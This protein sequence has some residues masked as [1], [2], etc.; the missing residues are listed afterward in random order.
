[1]KWKNCSMLFLCATL[2]VFS[3]SKNGSNGVDGT[4]GKDG[5]NGTNGA[6][7]KDGANGTN[8]ANG[9][10]GANGKTALTR[11][12]KEPAGANCTYGGTK[13]ET[14][15]DANNN[16]V[17]DDNEVTITQT[18]YVCDG[19]GAIYSS[20]I[21]VNVSDTITRLPEEQNFDFKQL[22]PATALTADIANKGLVLMYYKSKNGV[23]Y[24]VE[25]DDIFRIRD[26]SATGGIFDFTA[27]FVFKEKYLSFLVSSNM[28]E[29]NNNGSAVR[30]VLIP[31][32]VQGRSMND[33]KKMPYSEIAKLYNIND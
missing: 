11:T 2:F 22:L 3:C 13:F 31:G 15:I 21:T 12:T 27:A 25:R 18:K 14:G 16:G 1:M 7:G 29:I 20:W 8:G 4:N 26:V 6:N 17:L 30:Y 5:T 24:T 19:A 23:I 32:M 28:N 10:D 33:L 9:K